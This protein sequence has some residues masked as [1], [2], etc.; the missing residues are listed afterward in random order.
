[1]KNFVV[2]ANL[3]WF[4]KPSRGSSQCHALFTVAGLTPQQW[5][6]NETGSL[7]LLLSN[8]FLNFLQKHHIS[9]QILVSS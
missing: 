9:L 7:L 8:R 5:F 3:I 1:M 6:I 2:D 4:A